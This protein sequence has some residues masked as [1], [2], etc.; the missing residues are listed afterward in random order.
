MCGNVV[1][2]AKDLPKE[3]QLSGRIKAKSVWDYLSN[4]KIRGSKEISV[5]CFHAASKH[6]SNAYIAM[7]SYFAEKK[8]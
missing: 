4:I 2:I 7:L 5:V 6:D 1:D 8:R 3:V